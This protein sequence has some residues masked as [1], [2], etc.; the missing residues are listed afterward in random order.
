L[1]NWL[2]KNWKKIGSSAPL[3]LTGATYEEAVKGKTGIIF[4]GDYWHRDTD[5]KGERTGDHIDL[6]NTNTLGSM[7]GVGGRTFRTWFRRTFP[8][9]TEHVLSASDLTKS[10]VVIFWEIK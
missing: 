5:K 8:T 3:K 10:K 9:F 6:W 7:T 4:F 1:A 2:L